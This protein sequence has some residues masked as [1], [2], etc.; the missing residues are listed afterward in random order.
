[1]IDLVL[2][3]EGLETLGDEADRFPAGIQAFH[4]DLF[5]TDHVSGVVRHAQ[6]ALPENPFPFPA[7][8]DRVDQDDPPV[9]FLFGLPRNVADD[10]PAG[11]ADLRRSGR[12]APRN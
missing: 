11:L 4:P 9:V 6:A 7:A 5:G 8:D 3:G 10:D 1:M 2:E 12:G